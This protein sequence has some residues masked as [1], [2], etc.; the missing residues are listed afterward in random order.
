MSRNVGPLSLPWRDLFPLILGPFP[1][2]FSLTALFTWLTPSLCS[3]FKR[4][5]ISWGRPLPSHLFWHCACS[6]MPYKVFHM[7]LLTV[8]CCTHVQFYLSGPSNCFILD[9]I[10][11]NENEFIYKWNKRKFKKLILIRD[12][13]SLHELIYTCYT[14]PYYQLYEKIWFLRNSVIYNII[15]HIYYSKVKLRGERKVCTIYRLKSAFLFCWKDSYRK[16]LLHKEKF[17]V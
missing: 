6:A 14:F 16:V 3:C 11:M 13:L 12:L 5:T 9:F 17:M 8:S 4:V 7:C 10:K 1:M 2:L 15:L